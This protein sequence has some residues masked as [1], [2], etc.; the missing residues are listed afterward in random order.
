M[1]DLT[2]CQTKYCIYIILLLFILLRN[3]KNCIS[4]K[5]K[6]KNIDS[7]KNSNKLNHIPADGVKFIYIGNYAFIMVYAQLHTAIYFLIC[8][9][10]VCKYVYIYECLCSLLQINR[11][12]YSCADTRT[13]QNI[14]AMIRCRIVF[15]ADCCQILNACKYVCMYICVYISMYVRVCVMLDSKCNAFTRAFA[16]E[17]G[18]WIDSRAG[19]FCLTFF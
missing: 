9:M 13:K 7:H 8:R 12:R 3:Q 14:L 16:K 5:N 2:I 17:Y 11:Q 10:R 18:I 4:S 19:R 1:I 15:H 6:N